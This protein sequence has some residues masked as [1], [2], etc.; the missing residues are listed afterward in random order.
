MIRE[1]PKERITEKIIVQQ[2][3][4]RSG[5]GLGFFIFLIIVVIVVWGL[6]GGFAA[7]D[8]GV[9]CDMGVTETFCWKWHTN[10]VGQASEFLNNAFGW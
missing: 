3:A 2:P 5:M 7:Q 6:I 1:E 4:R 9:T 10:A 8:A